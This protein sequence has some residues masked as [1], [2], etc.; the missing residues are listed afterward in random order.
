MKFLFLSALLLPSLVTI[1]AASVVSRSLLFTP[2]ALDKSVRIRITPET[3]RDDDGP[4]VVHVD[5]W[6]RT[7]RSDSSSS[8]STQQSSTSLR[9]RRKDGIDPF[10]NI[11]G[12]AG[13][14]ASPSLPPSSVHSIQDSWKSLLSFS[15]GVFQDHVQPALADPE[16]KILKPVKAF[17]EQQAAAA[18]ERRQSYQKHA[19]AANDDTSTP[20]YYKAASSSA[21]AN[22]IFL[23]P[24]RIL[25]LAI[26]ALVLAQLLESFDILGDNQKVFAA[27][28]RHAQPA[29][30]DLRANV[31]RW[32]KAAT[33]T[34]GLL[35]AA[36]W[37]D[38]VLLSNSWKTQVSPKYQT[39]V[40]LGI[41]MV[42]SPVLWTAG[43][44]LLKTGLGAYVVAEVVH[45]LLG[46]QFGQEMDWSF[47]FGG[48][49]SR[50][51]EWNLDIA[52]TVCDLL[53]TWRHTVRDTIQRAQY[54]L[55]A[56]D[57]D[58][59][60]GY[61]YSYSYRSKPRRGDTGGLF[62][63]HMRRGVLIGAVIGVLVG[64]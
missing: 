57:D 51:A 18:A 28:K 40:G 7:T 4:L 16:R 59:I 29:W 31:Q 8:S 30:Q 15:Q 61:S 63:P 9:I 24:T 39:A 49:E 45:Q 44:G 48:T 2:W 54:V 47:P 21:S 11:R 26:L 55:Q 50:E 5:P 10:L 12:G 35:S 13:A 32:W 27:W 17:L 33:K 64:A 38:P 43:Q 41:G 25:R 23:E 22:N 19:N 3:S 62:P 1:T 36:T 60:S 6:M 34:G 56:R 20:P 14:G 53:E 42:F 58:D 52:T 37:S 46:S